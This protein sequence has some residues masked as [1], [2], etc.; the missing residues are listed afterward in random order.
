MCEDFESAY[1]Y[2]KTSL[3]RNKLREKRVPDSV[4]YEMY[5]YNYETDSDEIYIFDID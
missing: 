2:L 4:I 5:L 3:E 1:E